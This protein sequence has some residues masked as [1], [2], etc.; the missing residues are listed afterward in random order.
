MNPLNYRALQL[1]LYN[2]ILKGRRIFFKLE[3]DSSVLFCKGRRKWIQHFIQHYFWINFWV[4]LETMLDEVW[5]PSNFSSNIFL[6]ERRHFYI[7]F[8]V[9]CICV[10]MLDEDLWRFCA[11]DLSY[12]LSAFFPRDF[13]SN[14]SSNNE[15]E[16][17]DWILD[18]FAPALR[19]SKLGGQL[20]YFEIQKC[21]NNGG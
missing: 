18:S 3:N 2:L 5:S 7:G 11:N 19:T 16:I 13:S 1:T 4:H 15:F 10:I 12:I 9:G 17:L 20:L 14:I 8:N 21:L 6:W